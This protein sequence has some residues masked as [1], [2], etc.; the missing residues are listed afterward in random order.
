MQIVTAAVIEKNGKVLIA[1]R[2]KGDPLEEKWEFPGG[3]LEPRE[4][5]EDCLMRELREEFGMEVEVGEFIGTSTFIYRHASIKL[6]AFRVT[7]I[8]DVVELTAHEEIR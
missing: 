1:K 8:S 7:M 5:V 4:T 3:K 6:M 2:K